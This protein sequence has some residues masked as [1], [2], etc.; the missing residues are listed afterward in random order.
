MS[1]PKVVTPGEYQLEKFQEAESTS[2][3]TRRDV[4]KMARTQT[5]QNEEAREAIQHHSDHLKRFES[6]LLGAEAPDP[7]DPEKQVKVPGVISRLE[8]AECVL[9]GSYATGKVE[10]G[11]G[12]TLWAQAWSRERNALR[13]SFWKRLVWLVTGHVTLES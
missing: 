5:K 3:I 2:R 4:Y 13:S 11:P 9:F 10:D 7:D 8:S 6:L 1:T 12:L